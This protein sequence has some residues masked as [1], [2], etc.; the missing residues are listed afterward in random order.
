LSPCRENIAFAGMSLFRI[1]VPQTSF[2]P[3]EHAQK[4]GNRAKKCSVVVVVN[5]SAPGESASSCRRE[6][7]RSDPEGSGGI[8]LSGVQ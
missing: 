7:P 5:G 8:P 1:Q 6:Y 2:D 4:A 3:S